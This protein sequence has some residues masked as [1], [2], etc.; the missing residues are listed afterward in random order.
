MPNIINVV[1]KHAYP[2]QRSR[3]GLVHNLMYNDGI[4]K[5]P[6]ILKHLHIQHLVGVVSYLVSS[7]FMLFWAPYTH[8]IAPFLLAQDYVPGHPCFSILQETESLAAWE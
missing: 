8:T 5:W 7:L 1:E 3:E 2:L 6:K 4:E